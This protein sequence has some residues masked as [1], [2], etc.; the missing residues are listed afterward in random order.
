MNPGTLAP[1][2]TK[3]SATMVDAAKVRLLSLYLLLLGYFFLTVSLF[4]FFLPLVSVAVCFP[5]L[6]LFFISS[7]AWLCSC[8]Y[9]V[10]VSL[11]AMHCVSLCHVCL[12]RRQH[13]N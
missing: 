11:Y 5:L 2:I 3:T 8:I 6:S 1:V 12:A 4:F 13:F 10:F 7:Y 9:A